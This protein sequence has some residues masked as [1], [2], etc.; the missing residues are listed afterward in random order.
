M[1]ATTAGGTKVILI[2]VDT[3][4]EDMT[5]S[6]DCAKENIKMILNCSELFVFTLIT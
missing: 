5:C 3:I 1:N 6:M 4:N 2:D